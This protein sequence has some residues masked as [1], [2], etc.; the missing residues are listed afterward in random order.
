MA[1]PG[2]GGGGLVVCLK[3]DQNGRGFAPKWAWLLKF[4]VQ[5]PASRN[6]GSATV[7]YIIQ[8]ECENHNALNVHAL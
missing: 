4:R 3:N 2:G 1:D 6:P 8:I 5:G 7:L